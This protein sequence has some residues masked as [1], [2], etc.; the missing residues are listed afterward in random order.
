MGDIALAMHYMVYWTRDANLGY[1]QDTR[2]HIWPGGAADCSSLVIHVLKQAGFDTGSAWYT[3]DMVPALLGKGWRLVGFDDIQ[4]GDVLVTPGDHTAMVLQDGYHVGEAY[5]NEIGDIVGGRD[6]DQ[7]GY[8]TRYDQPWNYR[9]WE[10]C[11]RA[12]SNSS[13]AP[14]TIT[15]DEEDELMAV[16]DHIINTWLAPTWKLLEQVQAE[17]GDIKKNWLSPLWDKGVENADRLKRLEKRAAEVDDLLYGGSRRD[18]VWRPGTLKVVIEN[19]YR[20]DALRKE[21]AALK[22]AVEGKEGK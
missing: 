12:P 6:G 2:D 14:Q 17:I 22:A 18:G 1:G 16:A 10:Y 19:Q 11:L 8:E 5:I 20:T 13:N 15:D 3:G 7:T 4:P 9:T 21:I